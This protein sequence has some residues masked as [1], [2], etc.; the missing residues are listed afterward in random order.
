MSES[1]E[2]GE[3]TPTAPSGAAAGQRRAVVETYEARRVRRSA[4][5]RGGGPMLTSAGRNVLLA[6]VAVVV[7][8][9][10][11]VLLDLGASIGRVQPGVR[12]GSVAV[13]AMTP[14]QAQAA[15][16]TRFEASSKTPVTLTFGSQ[17]WKV[18]GP[19]VGAQLDTTGAVAAAMAVGRSGDFF[20]DLGAR[21]SALLGGVDVESHVT[22]EAAK[23][24]SLLDKVDA[25]VALPA[26][27]A[28]VSVAG[29]T[30]TFI[31]SKTGRMLERD[32]TGRAVLDAFLSTDHAAAVVDVPAGV[33]VVDA[34]ARQ[35]YADAQKLVAGP[36][37]VTY[38]KKTV[39]V[40]R[41]TVAGWVTFTRRPAQAPAI[42]LST[43]AAETSAAA[44][45]EPSQTATPRRMVLVASFDSARV[46]RAIAALTSG[47]GHPARNA[48]FKI[49]G[50]KIT[51]VPSQIGQGP[52][53]A[54]LAAD[55]AT[56]CVSGSSRS[57]VLRLVT[58]QPALTTGAAQQMGI[59]DR[60]SSFTTTYST[61]NPARTNNVHLL[62]K[63]FD[64][65]LVPPGGVF[66]F[67]QTAGERTAAKGYQEAPAIVN[68]K[69]VPELGGGVC[70]VGTTFFNTV[71]FSGLPILERHNHS[72]YI[73]HYPKGRDC[74][75]SWGGPDFK[76]KN[77][78]AGWLLIRTST[79]ASSLTISLYGTDP[80]YD[81]QYSTGQ[82][83][84]VVPFKVDQVKDPTLDKGIKIITDGGVNG[85]RIVVTRTVYKGA[86]VVRTDEFVSIYDPKDETVR[87][88]TKVASKPAT[89]TPTP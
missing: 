28:S 4:G 42:E 31:T 57:A 30:V 77:D 68:G 3:S 65:K 89:T 40:P 23:L 20:G 66:D 8:L 10:V 85:C 35:A 33:A 37:A 15:L 11:A 6:A 60:I 16:A 86:T 69:L 75:V 44:S 46:G 21:A 55:L 22:G 56:R 81:V 48:S 67:N 54:S 78:T 17:R 50:N 13:G 79:T 83:T 9:V 45:S 19:D 64:G 2:T 7:L 70:Q 36:V 76:F 34:D 87:V 27:D 52:D 29:T 14:E 62:A 82:F 61:A 73:S 63:T 74:T 49:V 51:V 5:T 72:F 32:A 71:F 12:V 38:G 84:N 18:A 24:A 26:R 41:E 47:V 88:G 59:S 25:T 1:P 39:A 53:L 80:G 58:T 43:P